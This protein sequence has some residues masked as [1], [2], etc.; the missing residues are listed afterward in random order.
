M[1]L[2]GLLNRGSMPV[3]QQVMAFTQERHEVLANNISNFDTV[4]YKMQDLPVEEFFGALDAAIADRDRGGAGR[5]LRMR[6]T[7]NL[8]WDAVGRLHAQPVEI[9]NNN[10]LF[11]DNNNR[12]VEKQMSAMA[13]NALLHNVSAEL[14]R[15][16]YESLQT[17]IRGRL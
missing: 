1:F 3:L 13:Q 9:E 8:H 15:G 2:E 17:A 5:P 11:H 10:I 12:F 16:Q 7:S 4:G 6:S 14:L